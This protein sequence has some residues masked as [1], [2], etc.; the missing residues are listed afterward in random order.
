MA[1]SQVMNK[2][3]INGV[4]TLIDYNKVLT[5]QPCKLAITETS[6]VAQ[7]TIAAGYVSEELHGILPALVNGQ[8]DIDV[9]FLLTVNGDMCIGHFEP[10]GSNN[11][12]KFINDSDSINSIIELNTEAIHFDGST[13]T[14]FYLSLED[15]NIDRTVSLKTIELQLQKLDRIMLPEE[16]DGVWDGAK[17]VSLRDAI[18]AL[19][20]GVYTKEYNSEGGGSG[21]N[22]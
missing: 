17:K 16:L 6:T 18:I 7:A 5:K 14:V 3:R 10:I 22:N 13:E 4:E 21:G 9:K 2:L 19:G 12:Y 1:T 15:S 20:N 11:V 8:S